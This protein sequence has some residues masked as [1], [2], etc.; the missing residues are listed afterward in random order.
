MH[1]E[2]VPTWDHVSMVVFGEAIEEAI[3]LGR[4]VFLG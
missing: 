4:G 2:Y 3:A 1:P